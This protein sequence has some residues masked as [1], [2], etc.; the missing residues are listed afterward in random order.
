MPGPDEER[1]TEQAAFEHAAGFKDAPSK[2]E[3]RARAAALVDAKAGEAEQEKVR[4]LAPEAKR[5]LTP[6]E[7]KDAVD[8]RKE[9]KVSTALLD[10]KAAAHAGLVDAINANVKIVLTTALRG[11]MATHGGI[12]A[13][14]VLN[15]F[16]WQAGNILAATIQGDLAPVIQ[17]RKMFGDM[18][19][20]GVRKAKIMPEQMPNG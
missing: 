3:A 14:L 15:A 16:A 6:N 12:P 19:A 4:D 20:D 5:R 13:Q 8:S 11:L 2:D 1:R 9:E 7:F 17:A 10:Q 18:F